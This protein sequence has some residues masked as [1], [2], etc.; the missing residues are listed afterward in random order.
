MPKSLPLTEFMHDPAPALD[1]RSPAEYIQGHI[2][3]SESFPLF[4]NTERSLIGTAYKKRGRQE[5]VELGLILIQPKID[6]L[7][8]RASSLLGSGSS[9]KVL[10]WRGGMRSG[11]T[12]R[13]LEL[14]GYKVHTLLGGYKTFRRWALQRLKSVSSANQTPYLNILGGLT[15][16]GKTAI[17]QALQKGGEQIIDLEALANH[18]GSS[19]GGIGLSNQP[20]QEQFEN[21]LAMQLQRLDWSK[22]IWIEDESRLIGRCH[23][24]QALYQCMQQAPLY[25]LQCSLGSRLEILLRQYGQ[26][27]KEQL[28]QA[29]RRI[30]KRLGSQRARETEQLFENG[31]KEEAFEQLLTYYDKT[32][33]HQLSTRQAI[34]T[35]T[36]KEASNPDDWAKILQTLYRQ[37][38]L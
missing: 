14:A 5:A 29:T 21:E 25:F 28:V 9:C 4:S 12:A 26:T 7:L 8:E 37:Q 36:E 13:L 2:P 20:T 10:C 15:G 16:S 19:F 23:L 27:P 1:V 3:G 18:R 24:P 34:H 22:P 32:Y 17:L 30:A 33:Q 38:S 31:R 35:L 6:S 11:F